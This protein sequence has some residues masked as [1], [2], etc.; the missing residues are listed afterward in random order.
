MNVLVLTNPSYGAFGYA[1]VA[2][3]LC[4]GLREAGHNPYVLSTLNIGDLIRDNYGTVNIPPYFIPFAKYALIQYIKALDI[5]VVVTLLDCWE[6]IAHDIP[7]K[8]HMCKIPVVGHVTARSSPLSPD[9]STYLRKVDHIVAPTMWGKAVVE[10][11][12]PG[13]VSRIEHGV[14]LDTF[15]P[16]AR[17]RKRMR[18]MLGYDD[19]FVFLMVGRNK[20]L[21]KR[22]DLALKAFK[23]LLTNMPE[24]QGKVVLHIHTN[25]HESYDLEA[26]RNMGFEDIGKEHVRFSRVKLNGDRLELCTEGDER[27][28][29]LNPNWGLDEK[30]MAEMY[31]MADCFVHSG[32][33]ESFCIP[34]VEAQACGLPCVVPAHSAFLET[35]GKPESGILAKIAIEETSPGL[36]DESLVDPIDLGKAMAIMFKD[37]ELR[38]R[39]SGNALR[40]AS[41]Y[42]WDVAVKKWVEVLENVVRPKPVNMMTESG[43][44]ELGI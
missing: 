12:F 29:F 40:N 10:E 41:K 5:D 1:M 36:T 31:N 9:W 32:G 8:V 3:Y 33:G 17:A 11:V 26:M 28:M 24:T 14:N 7:D 34:A 38:K 35:V 20:Q 39:C 23:G 30:A 4:K 16:D 25:P 18:K 19:K 6:Q 15:K 13:R 2:R 22:Y 37:P 27:G 42:G 43:I 21:Q 44:K